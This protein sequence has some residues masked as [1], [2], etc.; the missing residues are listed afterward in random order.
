M[1]NTPKIEAHDSVPQITP[2]VETSTK[3]KNSIST[4]AT[5]VNEHVFSKSLA[6][7][8]QASN[9]ICELSNLKYAIPASQ[10][11][12]HTS[13]ALQNTNK[14]KQLIQIRNK[15]AFA[16]REPQNIQSQIPP[17]KSHSTNISKSHHPK[18]KAV[19]FASCYSTIQSHLLQSKN[20]NLNH[21]LLVLKYVNTI[22]NKMPSKKRITRVRFN[23]ASRAAEQQS[24]SG[25]ATRPASQ[26][27]NSPSNSR[28]AN[29]QAES[30]S[31]PREAISPLNVTPTSP[32]HSSNATIPLTPSPHVPTFDYIV[33][34]I[35]NK[36]LIAS[37]TSKDAVLKE[38]RDHILTSNESRLKT[39]NPYIRSYWRDLHVR[40]GCVCIDEKV[41]ISDVL[42]EALIDD[43]HSSQP[44]TW[45]MICMA[46]HCWWPYIQRELIVKATECKP[47]TV[48]GKNLNSVIPAKQFNPHL[49]CVEPNQEIQIDFGGP[50]FD[51]RGNEV[52][53]LAA[54]YRFSKYPTAYIYDK[55]N[56]PNV[57][58]FLDIY[59]EIHGIP[60]SILD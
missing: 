15:T 4:H 36:S 31:N 6:P 29:Q 5:R 7:R 21:S 51:E 13:L 18:I 2:K 44:G 42:R 55:A 10:S 41:A 14:S 59:I 25:N 22:T 38:I 58:K 9:S 16:Q 43:I 32:T 19:L 50:I 60:R 53:F 56:G 24:T 33:S 17:I 11:P 34:K 40:S 1:Q 26:R 47:C 23:D 8:K 39:L 30:S 57:L 20:S 52:Y 49:P 3:S 12:I 45:G 27:L 35:F 37:L 28:A 48:T 54:I 46:T